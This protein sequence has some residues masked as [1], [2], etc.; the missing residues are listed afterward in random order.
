[1]KSTYVLG[2]HLNIVTDPN[3]RPRTLRVLNAATQ[4]IALIMQL[5]EASMSFRENMIGTGS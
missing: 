1:M 4:I 5:A 3:L 2:R